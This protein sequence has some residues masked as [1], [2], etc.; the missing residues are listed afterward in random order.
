[1]IVFKLGFILSGL[2]TLCTILG[3]K[4]KKTHTVFIYHMVNYIMFCSFN[5]DNYFNND[6]ME[7]VLMETILETILYIMS[8]LLFVTS[9]LFALIN[10]YH[11]MQIIFL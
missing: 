1:M 8:F 3:K 9:V 10:I 4:M 6:D 2:Y 5:I 11:C 7:Y